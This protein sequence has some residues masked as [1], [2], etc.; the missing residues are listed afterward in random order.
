MGQMHMVGMD[1]VNQMYAPHGF[2]HTGGYM[3]PEFTNTCQT[4]PQLVRCTEF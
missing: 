1:L 2:Q 4:V 3:L